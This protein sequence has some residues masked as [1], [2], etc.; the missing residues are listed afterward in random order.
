M[1]IHI[2]SMDLDDWASLHY[3]CQEHGAFHVRLHVSFPGE[4]ASDLQTAEVAGAATEE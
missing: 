2:S 4:I 1:E 3:R